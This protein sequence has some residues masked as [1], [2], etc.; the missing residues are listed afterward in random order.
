[1]QFISTTPQIIGLR[2][3]GLNEV[4]QVEFL[5]KDGNDNPVSNQT[6]NFTLSTTVGGI[7]LSRTSDVSDTDGLVRA[8]V[9]SGNIATSVRVTA[10]LASNPSISTQSD[11]L[12]IGIGIADQNSMSLSLSD[13][14]PEAFDIDGQ[15]VTVTI[16]AADHFNNPVPDGTAVSFT[17]EG[18]Q[19]QPQCLTN[20]G[21][22]SVIWTSSNPR[23]QN[24]ARVTLLATLLGEEDFH[25]GVSNGVLDATDTFVDMPEAFR[26]D[27][28]NGQFDI[29]SEEFLDF[30]S[31]GAYDLT[32][33]EFNGTLCCDNT[34][35]ASA[36]AG[37]ACYNRTPTS[38]ICSSSKNIHVRGVGVIVMA[39][40][41]VS[42]M[43]DKG[44]L[45]GTGQT[46]DT[47]TIHAFSDM[48]DGPQQPPSGTVIKI[49]STNG[50]LESVNSYTVP[51]SNDNGAYSQVAR[52]RGDSS[53]SGGTMTITATSPSG[54]V[55]APLYIDLND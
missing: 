2:G 45:D 12:S 31:N 7:N 1:M 54:L 13:L 47:L 25:D 40:S 42:L 17:A 43:A 53:T 28:E 15:Q 33:G 8:D 38:E 6:V 14:N 21:H 18:G 35:V 27:N 30:N 26:D 55:S 46:L 24:D 44:A 34:N 52:W 5:V 50:R 3:F 29:A 23:P 22:C 36:V 51:Q 11:G 32:D 20:D 16:H 48:P 4:A 37:E 49:T 9:Q 19:I 41:A 39:K 10:T